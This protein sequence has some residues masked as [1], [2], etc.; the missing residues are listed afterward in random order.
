M[1][2]I[3]IYGPPAVGKLT[4][5]KELSRRSGYKLYDNHSIMTPLG[6]L[7]SYTDPRLNKIRSEL[8]ER[9]RLDIFAA[10]A[11]ANINFITTSARAG[12]KDFKFFREV[13][14]AV[15]KN[16]GSVYFVQL[17]ASKRALH[18]RVEDESRRGIKADTRERLNQIL[19]SNPEIFDT[20][21]DV[22][23]LTIDTEKV[24]WEDAANQIISYH[25]I[26]PPVEKEG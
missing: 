1:N 13:V 17:T 4:V 15:T 25:G 21:P 19:T 12:T 6:E 5:A 3:Y 23:H 22:E 24:S 11:E 18:D 26:I 2:L 20:F 7:F 14:D 9:L 16:G 10:A 8:G